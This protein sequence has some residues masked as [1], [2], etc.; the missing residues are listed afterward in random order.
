M[1]TRT[2]LALVGIA[3]ILTGCFKEEFAF[4]PPDMNVTLHFRLPDPATR[5]GDTFLNDISTVTTVIY[6]DA[7]GALVRTIVTNDADHRVFKGLHLSLAAGTYRVV[8]WGNSGNGTK[9]NALDTPY[10]NYSWL[11]YTDIRDNKTGNGD[12]LYYAHHAGTATGADDEY[13]MTVDPSTGHEGTLD[14]HHAH[15]RIEIYVKGFSASG[16]NTPLIRLSGLPTGLSFLGMR[17]H[18][19][20]DRVT[21]ELASQMVTVGASRAAAGAYALSPF[22]VFY[23]NTGDYDIG[24]GLLDPV[25]GDSVYT[26][27]LNEHIDP[28]TDNPD[29]KMVLQLLIEFIGVEVKVSVPEWKSE[30][31]DYGWWD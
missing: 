16:S 24:V 28:L 25:T 15:R 4:C 18:T 5:Q 30:D 7:T 6:D 17:P 26:T 3:T 2:I 11:D 20:S 19:S 10:N 13:T 12:A 23:L 9:F 31:V 21:S 14:F 1:K 8:S 29:N 27:R 22:N